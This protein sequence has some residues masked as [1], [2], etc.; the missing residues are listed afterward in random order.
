MPRNLSKI[1]PLV[2]LTISV[3]TFSTAIFA[4]EGSGTKANTSENK[5]AFGDA[6]N[7]NNRLKE[8]KSEIRELLAS[9]NSLRTE[10]NE[11]RTE[12]SE[13]AK[14]NPQ[15]LEE[16]VELIAMRLELLK[17]EKQILALSEDIVKEQRIANE[18]HAEL[19][20]K[21]FARLL[22]RAMK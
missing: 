14:T 9:R 3:A 11:S 15:S 19:L 8:V 16:K 20:Q 12:I 1:L 17:L 13:K 10:V 21:Q 7:P 22:D 6:D 18:L 4:Q 2:A 5:A